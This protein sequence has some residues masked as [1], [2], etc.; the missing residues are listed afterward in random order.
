MKSS[1]R[2]ILGKCCSCIIYYKTYTMYFVLK[3]YFDVIKQI[4]E[5][6]IF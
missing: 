5:S 3:M 6:N 1:K 2:N 4:L